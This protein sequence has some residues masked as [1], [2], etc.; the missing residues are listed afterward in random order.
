[1]SDVKVGEF[2]WNELMTS[3]VSKAKEFYQSLFGWEIQEHNMGENFTYNMFKKGDKD[4]GGMMAI[5]AEKRNQMPSHW[6]SYIC[7]EQLDEM[8][9]KAKG[10]GATIKQEP[11]AVGDFGLLAVL[12]DPSGAHIALW[13][14]TKPC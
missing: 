1:M 14:S 12:E 3:D 10:L 6:M 9:E 2:C 4:V 13:Q 11:V 8:V 5:P 7:V